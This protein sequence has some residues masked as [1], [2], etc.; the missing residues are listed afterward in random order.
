MFKIN[1]NISK[2]PLEYAKTRRQTHQNWKLKD[3]YTGLGVTCL[4][5]N[6]LMTTYFIIFDSGRRN[7]PDAFQIPFFGPFL[8]K[9]KF[10]SIK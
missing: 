7:F 9:L 8:S 4:R 3:A 1:N 6:L 10:L 2:T 5:A